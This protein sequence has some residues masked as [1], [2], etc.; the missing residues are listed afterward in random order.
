MANQISD[1]IAPA[2]FPLLS[3][4]MEIEIQILKKILVMVIINILSTY[5]EP[6]IE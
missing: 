4:E 6:G 2:F 5:D 3:Q 1:S